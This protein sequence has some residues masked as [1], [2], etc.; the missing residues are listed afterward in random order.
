MARD[1]SRVF[2]STAAP[3][4]VVLVRLGDGS[5]EMRLVNRR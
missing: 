2:V 4:R 5:Q 3:R 1:T